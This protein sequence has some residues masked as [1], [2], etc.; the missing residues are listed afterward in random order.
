MFVY[1]CLN[2]CWRVLKFITFNS[3]LIHV[4]FFHTHAGSLPT[5]A[6]RR[7]TYAHEMDG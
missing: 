5:N 4:D 3:I 6:E 1:T 2:A 7:E